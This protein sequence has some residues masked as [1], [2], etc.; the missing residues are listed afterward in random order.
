MKLFSN[1]P[2]DI[3]EEPSSNSLV[4]LPTVSAALYS[5]QQALALECLGRKLA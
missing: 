5:A 1:G 4:Q 2:D 3:I